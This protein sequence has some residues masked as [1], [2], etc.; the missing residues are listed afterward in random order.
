MVVGVVVGI[1]GLGEPMPVSPGAILLRMG[2]W[3]LILYG[4]IIL[5]GGVRFVKDVAFWLIQFVPAP[6]WQYLPT[7]VAVKIKN[8]AAQEHG[9][10]EHRPPANVK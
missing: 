10:P 2:S 6:Y 5:S 3:M 8:W 4:V 7:E 1:I 9:L